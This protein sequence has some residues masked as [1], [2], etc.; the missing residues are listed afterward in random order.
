MQAGSTRPK[1]KSNWGML[2]APPDNCRG[3]KTL[4]LDLDETLVHSQFNQIKNPDY[5]IPVNIE[6]NVCN[7]FVKKRPGVD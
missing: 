7:I 5:I 1:V 3:M 2:G 4:I 6:G